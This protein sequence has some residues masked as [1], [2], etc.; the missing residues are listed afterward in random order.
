M[1]NDNSSTEGD[2]HDNAANPYQPPQLRDLF[3]SKLQ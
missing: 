2:S 1:D 3:G